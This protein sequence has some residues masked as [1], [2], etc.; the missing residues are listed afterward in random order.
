MR[1]FLWEFFVFGL[2]EAR[3]CLFAGLFF[4]LLFLSHHL[5]LFGLPRYDFLCLAA[6]AIQVVL[7][8]TRAGNPGRG[9]HLCAFH[10]LGVALELFKTSPGRRLVVVPGV[11]VSQDR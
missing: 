9:P 10:V 11:R 3:A 5:P 6:V 1:A 2:K 8:V 4:G 7:L